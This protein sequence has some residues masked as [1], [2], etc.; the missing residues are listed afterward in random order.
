MLLKRGTAS[1]IGL[2]LCC[3]GS[4]ALP[5]V[6]STGPAAQR[7]IAGHHAL[8][9]VSD[10]GVEDG[11]AAACLDYPEYVDFLR[12][13][14][15][16]DFADLFKYDAEV[17]L[18]LDYRTSF[19]RL[20]K[21]TGARDYR[22]VTPFEMAMT[23]DILGVG[24]DYVYIGDFKFGYSKLGAAKDSAQMHAPAVA[25]AD[26][27]KKPRAIVEYIYV[28]R[29]YRDRAELDI[30]DL[31][32]FSRKLSRLHT[33]FVAAADAVSRG[34]APDVNAGRWCR[35]C[36]AQTACPA[37]KSLAIELAT[38]N[39]TV[40]FNTPVTRSQ[41]ADAYEK[42][43][44]A[45]NLLNKVTASIYAEAEREPI[46]LRNGKM[47]G[48][49]RKEGNEALDGEVAYKVLTELVDPSVAGSAFKHT[50]S[51][52]AIAEFVKEHALVVTKAIDPGAEK[53]LSQRAL[54]KEVLNR[55]RDAGGVTKKPSVNVE[56][57]N[58][59]R[60]M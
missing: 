36:P 31:N 18:A 46:Q 22:E 38:C 40:P 29:G 10:L 16:E 60:K 14:P 23:P 17:P 1:K 28:D 20:L 12:D 44:L 9:M 41:M 45:Q 30:F 48:Q 37:Q 39:D 58:A 35:N 5:W 55:I 50:A 2:A 25:A 6:K 57:Y 54:N 33:Q 43:K 42:V 26:I 3:P 49:V 53:S 19:G 47:L 59:L 51:K 56:E 32:R 15:Y 24:K 27:F 34:Q 4:H 52:K 21:A 13:I 11:L 7:G 8:R